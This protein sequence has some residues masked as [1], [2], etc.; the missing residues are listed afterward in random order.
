VTPRRTLRTAARLSRALGLLAALGGCSSGPTEDPQ[1]KRDLCDSL[2]RDYTAALFAA[3]ECTPG[4]ANA[5]N[6]MIPAAL[7]CPPC[8]ANVD[9]DIIQAG[10]IAA[11]YQAAGCPTDCSGCLRQPGAPGCGVDATSSKNGRCF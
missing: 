1:A 2:T 10:L 5:C 6:K 7:S 8:G 3:R 11:H 4:A 9:G